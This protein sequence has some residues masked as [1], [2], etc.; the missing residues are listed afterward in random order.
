MN[1][2][3]RAV[4]QALEGSGHHPVPVR[5][6]TSALQVHTNSRRTRAYV[7]SQHHVVA[8]PSFAPAV[9]PVTDLYAVADPALLG[10]IRSAAVGRPVSRRESFRGVW[11]AC[12]KTGG[13]GA[14]MLV[15]DGHA[16]QHALLTRDFRSWAVVGDRREDLG[17][18]V[19]RTVRELVRED[20]L[21]RGAVT[22]HGAAAELAG[23]GGGVLLAGASGA[24]KTS[25]AIRVGRGGGRAVGTDRSFLLEWG[26]TRILV[27][28][29]ESTRLSVGSAEAMGIAR[30]LR[31]RSPI[32]G[33][34]P[35]A[36]GGTDRSGEGPRTAKE[37]KV[38]LSNAEVHELLG[39]GFVAATPADSLVVLESMPHASPRLDDL[40]PAEAVAAL[41]PHLLAPDPDYRSRWL[42]AEPGSEAPEAAT[43]RLSALVDGRPVRRLVWD[44]ALHC[45]DTVAQL[46]SPD[47]GRTVPDTT[48]LATRAERNVRR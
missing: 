36:Q 20:L 10:I 9:L 37:P 48:A 31:E 35:F 42:T 8:H 33:L 47:T 1:L 34:N 26:G 45:D 29:P 14:V 21:R 15:D 4:Q 13:D 32:R 30:A 18:V 39:C 24:G 3:E 11:Y 16:Y 22:F 2:Y 43:A 6:F 19:S 23:G 38:S 40:D 28:L 25:A 12:W 5:W 17:P 44:P 7:A 46:L 41:R 27:G